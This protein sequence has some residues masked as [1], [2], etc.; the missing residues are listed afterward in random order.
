[1]SVPLYFVEEPQR[2][3]GSIHRIQFYRVNV[4]PEVP[5]SSLSSPPLT[6]IPALQIPFTE[7]PD[8]SSSCKQSKSSTGSIHTP[9]PLWRSLSHQ[10]SWESPGPCVATINTAIIIIKAQRLKTRSIFPLG[11]KVDLAI[12]PL[13]PTVGR[14]RMSVET[15]GHSALEWLC[16]SIPVP[17]AVS[18]QEPLL[19][20][21]HQQQLLTG[22]Q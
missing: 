6:N 3:P 17:R 8:L 19:V 16:G 22:Q 7:R 20:T 9:T 12:V 13:S 2:A 1:M 4:T 5:F 11:T 10:W 14:S 15:E 21:C 18:L